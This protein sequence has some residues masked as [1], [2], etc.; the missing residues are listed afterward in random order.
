MTFADSTF[1]DLT[2]ADLTFANCVILWRCIIIYKYNLSWQT[3]QAS[4]LTVR[5]VYNQLQPRK[6]PGRFLD[7]STD[8]EHQV[9]LHIY[10]NTEELNSHKKT[11]SRI[12]P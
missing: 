1:A 7:D 4:V 2:F 6:T 5:Q 9:D 10:K 8:T 12:V 11:D 3:R